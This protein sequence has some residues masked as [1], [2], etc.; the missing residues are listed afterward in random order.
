MKRFS[1]F[2]FFIFPL[3]GETTNRDVQLWLANYLRQPLLKNILFLGEIQHRFDN[4]VSN[5]FYWHLQEQ[6][7][8]NIQWLEVAL[9]YRQTYTKFQEPIIWN[10]SHG[11]V[12]DL[13]LFKTYRQMNLESRFRMQHMTDNGVS[14]FIY[15]ER[16]WMNTPIFKGVDICLEEE[17]FFTE[18]IG[19]S[20]N[21]ITVGG[22]IYPNSVVSFRPFYRLRYLKVSRTNWEYQNVLGFYGSFH[23]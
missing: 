12:F 11:V 8:Y 13:S 10:S 21:R 4:K 3:F 2:L 19:F 15:R 6:I 18:G 22:I 5:F 1:F 9:G 17:F 23:F 7:G 20:Q 16:F 14:F